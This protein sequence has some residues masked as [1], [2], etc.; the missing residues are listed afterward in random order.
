[1]SAQLPGVQPASTA[2]SPDDPREIGGYRLHARLGA[3]GMGVVYLAYTPGGR[4]IALK[5]VRAEFAADPEFRE[6]FAQEVASARRI[7]GLFTAQVV[8]S[9]V[10]A[11]TPWLA[12]AY[13]PGP[14]L[15]QVVQ[16]H[17]PLPVR[18]VLL[19]VAG[20]AEA[21]QGI[22]GVGVVHRDLKPA[23]VLIASDGPRV[24]DFGIA[25]A[26]DAAALTGAG[27]RIGT[28]AF[29]AP[30]QAL[31]IQ[32]TAATD[33]FALGALAAYV[34]GGAPPFGNGPE[35]AALYRV[36]HEEPDLAGV[37][38]GLR[39]LVR[40]CL[41]KRPEDRPT[42][43]EVIAA[44]HA[45]PAVGARP[46]F[47]DDWLPHPVSADI[48]GHG[49]GPTPSYA[50]PTATATATAT[51]FPSEGVPR[52]IDSARGSAGA[53]GTA[54]SGGVAERP[55]EVRAHAPSSRRAPRR[56]GRL[57][58]TA[59]VAV[60]AL[61]VGGAAVYS[62][63]YLPE[64]GTEPAGASGEPSSPPVTVGPSSSA[65]KPSAGYVPGY[66]GVELTSPDSSYEFDIQAG[67]V[68]PADTASWYL[69][70]GDG[71]FVLPEESDAFVGSGD[72]LSV[73]ECVHGIESEPVTALP[74]AE[75]ADERPFCVR[76]AD[77]KDI[78]IA[79]LVEATSGGGSVTVVVDRYRRAG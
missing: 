24:I 23:N 33:V 42:T 63:D 72:G 3:G 53:S 6:R 43:A 1:M 32:A 16:R 50:Q 79:R 2:L 61:V 26:A 76:S 8:D 56:G 41:A 70:I 18:T 10:D 64:E 36:V 75:L 29:M 40:H 69:A 38:A 20:I 11:R 13:V 35:S 48:A 54:S 19:L 34:S 65:P 55:V 45:H 5:A 62:L 66:A 67:K 46:E 31:G 12:T 7:H 60:L 21:L 25:R 17:G 39:D 4:P 52:G 78:V 59:L 57:L 47:A 71:A 58:L 30:E 77:Q 73:A 44:V 49:V 22:H 14:T 9:G 27:L 74:F 37:P 15:Q 28:A 68:V 51:A